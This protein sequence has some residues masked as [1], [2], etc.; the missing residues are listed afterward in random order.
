MP[1]LHLYVPKQVASTLQKRA[2]ARGLSLSKYLAEI[3]Q[4]DI[5]AEWPAGFFD[6]VLGSWKGKPLERPPQGKLEK[7]EDL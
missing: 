7:R 6:Q 2:A 5:G 1:Q 4:R 3:V